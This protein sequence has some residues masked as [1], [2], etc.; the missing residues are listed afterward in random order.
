MH[1]LALRLQ[2]QVEEHICTVGQQELLLDFQVLNQVVRGG[3]GSPVLALDG[4]S[5]GQGQWSDVVVVGYT[6]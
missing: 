4:V 2:H 5:W 1:T 3:G 6:R